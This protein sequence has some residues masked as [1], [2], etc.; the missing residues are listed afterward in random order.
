MWKRGPDGPDGLQAEGD[1][2]DAIPSSRG[3]TFRA[4]PAALRK[5]WG[6]P[7]RHG[8]QG[9]S[10]QTRE[11]PEHQVRTSTSSSIRSRSSKPPLSRPC[12]AAAIPAADAWGPIRP[13]LDEAERLARLRCPHARAATSRRVYALRVSPFCCCGPRATPSR[14][15]RPQPLCRISTR[16]VSAGSGPPTLPGTRRQP[17]EPL[18]LTSP[19]SNACLNPVAQKPSIAPSHCLTLA[20]TP[21][22]RPPQV[23]NVAPTGKVPPSEGVPSGLVKVKRNVA[24]QPGALEAVT[25]LL[26][27]NWYLFPHC[28]FVWTTFSL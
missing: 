11:M 19:I 26:C 15:C 27:Q 3:W 13:D 12:E 24:G 20:L 8:H 5:S 28:S 1:D 23:W 4:Q 17:E 22:G 2:A 7:V 18:C 10:S 14:W 6:R 21:R 16:S 25:V 9:G